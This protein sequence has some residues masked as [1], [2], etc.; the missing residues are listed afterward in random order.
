MTL[1]KRTNCLYRGWTRKHSTCFFIQQH[2][3][4]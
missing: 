2:L 3:E 4:P 1:L